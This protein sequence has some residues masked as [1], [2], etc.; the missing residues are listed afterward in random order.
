[1]KQEQA[2]SNPKGGGE[3]RGRDEGR[4]IS[5][6]PKGQVGR[7]CRSNSPVRQ[8][9][10]LARSNPPVRRA[11]QCIRSNSPLRRVGR[12]VFCCLGSVVRGLE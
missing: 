10:L 3:L 5:I 6:S 9:G 4:L 12:W 1:M 2:R 7:R 8:V 11:G